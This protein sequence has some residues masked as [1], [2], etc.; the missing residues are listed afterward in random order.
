MMTQTAPAGK[1]LATGLMAGLVV[2]LL[3]VGGSTVLVPA[4]TFWIGMEEHE[5]HGSTTAVILPTAVVGLVVYLM[6][7]LA[8]WGLALNIGLGG[9]VGAY[10]GTV[11]MPHISP[12]WL[13]RIFAT[14]C[15]L[16]GWQMLR[17]V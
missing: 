2:G 12:I 4:M 3:G 10:L 7:G 17:A 8:N 9:A 16:A 1:L 5:A 6:Q 14:T 11:L 15:L 13:R